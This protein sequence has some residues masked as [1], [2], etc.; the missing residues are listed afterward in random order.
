M[1][2]EGDL[3][4]FGHSFHYLGSD[5]WNDSTDDLTGRMFSGYLH[6]RRRSKSLVDIVRVQLL[7]MNMRS[8]F[9]RD[10]NYFAQCMWNACN[11]PTHGKDIVTLRQLYAPVDVEDITS[12]TFIPQPDLLDD[13]RDP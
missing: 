12:R 10:S 9:C 7:V 2:Q 5:K 3:L 6:F 8:E 4:S 13:C 1:L 11:A